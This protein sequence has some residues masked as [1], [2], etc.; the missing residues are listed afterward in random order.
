[1]KI[2]KCKK[3]IT[4]KHFWDEDWKKYARICLA[5]GLV[6]DTFKSRRN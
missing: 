5:C 6:D 2:S 1:M 3:T 4:G